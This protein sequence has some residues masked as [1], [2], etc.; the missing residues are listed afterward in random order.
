[1][2]SVL[3]PFS[4]AFSFCC[5]AH[6]RCY[7]VHVTQKVQILCP[8]QCLEN[9]GNS[10]VWRASTPL[11]IPW[12]SA[13][14]R[15]QKKIGSL[16]ASFRHFTPLAGIIFKPIPPLASRMTDG[17][18]ASSD[19]PISSSVRSHFLPRLFTLGSELR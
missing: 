4:I 3:S 5:Y 10:F 9:V 15:N 16:M 18:A 1:M 8:S 2:L 19:S 6:K 14:L 12:Y 7:V 17:F 13:F 11:V